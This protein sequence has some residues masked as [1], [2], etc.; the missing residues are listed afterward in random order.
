M[1][2][3]DLEYLHQVEACLEMKDF[4][5]EAWS[6]SGCRHT[7]HV[8]LK[9]KEQIV[10]QVASNNVHDE[11]INPFQGYMSRISMANRCL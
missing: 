11:Y 8:R 1:F 3:S 4:H 6:Y 5:S 9:A 7:G 10:S 2:L